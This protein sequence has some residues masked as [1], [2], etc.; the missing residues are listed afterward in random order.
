MKNKCGRE[1]RSDVTEASA[2]LVLQLSDW[3]WLPTTAVLF[4]VCDCVS[5]GLTQHG[6]S[7]RT[8]PHG[9]LDSLALEHSIVH[10]LDALDSQMM[11][12]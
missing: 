8:G 10:Q 1:K 9:S 11:L 6:E 7:G 3:R 2:W 4:G 12:S 5:F